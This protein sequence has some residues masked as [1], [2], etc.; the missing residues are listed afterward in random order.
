MNTVCLAVVMALAV[1]TLGTVSVSWAA[2]DDAGLGMTITATA[3]ADSP[4]VVISGHTIKADPVLFKTLS[5]THNMVWADQV[6]PNDVGEFE[7]SFNISGMS[8]NGLY[9]IVANQGLTELYELKVQVN[10]VDGIA[11]DTVATQ[12]N[13]EK[14]V[15]VVG[16]D[17]FAGGLDMTAEAM[18]GSDTIYIT[19]QTD[20]R[21]KHVTLTVYAPNGNVISVDQVR[22]NLLD[23][24]FYHELMIGG[25]LW[26]QDGDY[27]VVAQQDQIGYEVSTT[28]GIQDGV[29]IP[30]FGTVAVLILAVAIV[31]IIVTSSKSGLNMIPRF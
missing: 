17:L 16:T 26:S 6:S 11:E 28:V 30:E 21:N 19:G 18:E 12:S 10:V 20:V 13:F 27:T 24:L 2:S 15:A 7:T 29:A 14:A 8:E 9:T 5:P 1:A 4:I 22:A 3:N 31:A 25:P 23:G